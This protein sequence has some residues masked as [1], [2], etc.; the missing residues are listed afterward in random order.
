MARYDHIFVEEPFNRNKQTSKQITPRLIIFSD[1]KS[2]VFI[3]KHWG[4]I[5]YLLEIGI[6]NLLPCSLKAHKLLSWC[7]YWIRSISLFIYLFLSS[8]CCCC[9]FVNSFTFNITNDY[10]NKL[11]LKMMGSWCVERKFCKRKQNNLA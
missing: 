5:F 1:A 3:W 7:N 11:M 8:F 4:Y 10:L 9:C 2:Y 6:H